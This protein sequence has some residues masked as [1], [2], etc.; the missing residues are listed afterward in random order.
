MTT[1]TVLTIVLGLVLV[2]VRLAVGA[3]R[4][5]RLSPAGRRHWLPARWGRFR[6]RFVCSVLDLAY[7]DTHHRRTWRPRLPRSTAVHVSPAPVHLM[8]CPTAKFWPDDSG[9]AVRVRLTHGVTRQDFENKAAGLAGVWRAH[10]VGITQPEPGRL[11][12]RAVRRDPLLAPVSADVLAPFD[13]RNLT[14]GVDEWGQLRTA[15]LANMS[16][17]VIG[18]SPGA[19]KTT[20]GAAVAVQLAQSPAVQMFCLDG[21]GG[22]DWSGW[23]GR[24]IAYAG[25]QL[26]DAQAVLERAHARM[27]S[28]LATVTADLG[29]RNAWRIGPSKDYPLVWVVVD[30]CHQYLDLESAK[31]LGK[32]TERQVRACRML[33]GEMLRKGRSVLYHTSLLAQKCTSTSIPTDLRDLAGLRICF[34]VATLESGIAVLGED[35]RRYESASPTLLHGEEYAG[36]ATVRLA[37]GSDPYTRLRAPD[38]SEDLA[39]EVARSTAH[40]SERH[41]PVPVLRSV[42]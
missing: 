9:W 26:D 38:V 4:F 22:G 28:R 40:L 31:A 36:V 13:G 3:V 6:W 10:R 14:L 33:L 12:L 8:R 17:S 19:G 2:L 25:D 27:R 34:Q 37:T 32:D 7:L 5:A 35:L 41:T 21:K 23:A 39:D 11:V 42:G 16:G 15:S 18:G 30:E 29:V 20:F 24:S 1:I